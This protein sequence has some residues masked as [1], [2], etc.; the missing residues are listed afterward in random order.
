MRRYWIYRDED[1]T[2]CLREAGYF[3]IVADAESVIRALE[4]ETGEQYY[5]TVYRDEN[6]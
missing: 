6:Q 4:V 5:R 3:D 2:D 1:R